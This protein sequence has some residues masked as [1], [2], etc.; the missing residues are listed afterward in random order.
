MR[1]ALFIRPL[2][3]H[4][5]WFCTMVCVLGVVGC[6]AS[7]TAGC[8]LYA[9]GEQ[10]EVKTVS[11]RLRGGISDATVYI[12]DLYLGDLAFV[13]SR[14]VAMPPGKHRISVVRTG[15]FPWDKDLEVREGDPLVALDV[16]LVAIP[17]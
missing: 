6:M 14:G 17:D 13:Q 3:G 10:P 2:A 11:L 4:F 16:Q 9:P 5:S 7:A 1:K 8:R 12:D 15:Y